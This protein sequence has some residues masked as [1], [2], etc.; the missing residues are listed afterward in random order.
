MTI[1]DRIREL[2]ARELPFSQI[3]S[4]ISVE[5]G[6]EFT[7]DMVQK[8]Y[9]RRF[10][11]DNPQHLAADAARRY[12]QTTLKPREKVAS[13]IEDRRKIVCIGDLHGKPHPG[14]LSTVLQTNPD[15]VVIGG[16]IFDQ[17]QFSHHER[18]IDAREDAFEVEMQHMRAFLEVLHEHTEAIVVV[19]GN[20]DNRMFRM[21]SEL[22]PQHLLRYFN[23]PLDVLV[24]G[25]PRIEL[26]RNDLYANRPGLTKEGIGYVRHVYVLGDALVSHA[27]FS[28]AE[29]FYYK[30]VV[31][32]RRFL[33]W[34]EFSVLIQH[35]THAFKHQLC[36][37]GHLTLLDAGMGGEA[38]IEQYKVEASAKWK[39]GQLGFVYF[40]QN[41]NG[42]RWVSDH[43]SVRLIWPTDADATAVV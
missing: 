9:Q 7:K 41:K 14:I 20:H 10:R 43:R 2:R 24:S 4:M 32:W 30:W 34:P 8:L 33:G 40:E 27:H 42:D 21:L 11:V 17:A 5:F 36:E 28:S 39:P 31:K 35:H 29:D 19:R 18:G 37:G 15:M 6:G 23:D 25:L 38:S 1:I 16:D 3:A 12:L 13:T 26:V 22:L